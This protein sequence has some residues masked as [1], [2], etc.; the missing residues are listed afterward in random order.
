MEI[1]TSTTRARYDNFF[2]KSTERGGSTLLVKAWTWKGPPCD[3]STLNLILSTIVVNLVVAYF[4]QIIHCKGHSASAIKWLR[5]IDFVFLHWRQIIQL[6]HLFVFRMSFA[7]QI[8]L[9]DRNL[10]SPKLVNVK[11]ARKTYLLG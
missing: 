7:A 3:N 2:R 4:D 6:N 10:K 5:G 9:H 8:W 1:S 11:V